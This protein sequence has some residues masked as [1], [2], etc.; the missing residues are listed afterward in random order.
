MNG[1]EQLIAIVVGIM[2]LAGVVLG[3]RCIRQRSSLQTRWMK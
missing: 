2:F 3:I 1:S